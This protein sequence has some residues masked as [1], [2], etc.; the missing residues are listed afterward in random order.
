MGSTHLLARCTAREYYYHITI[1]MNCLMLSL[2]SVITI[3]MN[4]MQFGESS[5]SSQFVEETEDL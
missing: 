4:L 5:Y 3:R 2:A 1:R